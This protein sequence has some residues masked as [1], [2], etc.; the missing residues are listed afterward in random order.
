MILLPLFIL[1][2]K[3]SKVGDKAE[4][5]PDHRVFNDESGA[6]DIRLLLIFPL[7][8]ITERILKNI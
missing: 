3:C 8:E 4:F 5:C 1:H 6:A 7:E 2:F